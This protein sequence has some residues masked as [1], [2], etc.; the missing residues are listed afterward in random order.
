MLQRPAHLPCL[1]DGEIQLQSAT[2][3]G[4]FKFGPN[5]MGTELLK[6]VWFCVSSLTLLVPGSLP[7]LGGTQLVW[8]GD[9]PNPL[10]P[11]STARWRG[12]RLQ[13]R[14]SPV[15]AVPAV[16]T[17]GGRRLLPL[18]AQCAQCP[19][20]H[21]RRPALA[22]SLHPSPQGFFSN[23]INDLQLAATK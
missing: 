2:H 16:P 8:C 7:K 12:R 19:V 6:S 13:L 15:K 22:A 14:S 17:G 3:V 9:P 1:S 5:I 23:W 11:G 20:R 10:Q 21:S 4:L 18:S